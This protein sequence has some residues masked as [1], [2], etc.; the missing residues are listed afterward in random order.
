MLKIIQKNVVGVV[1]VASISSCTVSQ[2]EFYENKN[3]LSVESLCKTLTRTS[4]PE[5]ANQLIN[6]ISAKG[7]RPSDC[8][9]IIKKHEQEVAA[10]IMAAVVIGGAIAVCASGGCGG[11]GYSQSV[12][13]D[14]DYFFWNGQYVRR[15]RDHNSGQFLND[16]Q[17]AASP[18]YDHF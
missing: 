1:I 8:P 7:V 5:F 12:D 9:A 4:D 16:Y 17:C 2:R 13:P 15:C 10:G 14:W 18:A 3:S 11:G 6:T